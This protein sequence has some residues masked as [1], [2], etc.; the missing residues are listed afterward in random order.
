MFFRKWKRF[1]FEMTPP[2]TA[3]ATVDAGDGRS[4]K[5]NTLKAFFID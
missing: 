1:A 3:A 2:L 4:T 5:V